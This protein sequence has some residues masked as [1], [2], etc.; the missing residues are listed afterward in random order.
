MAGIPTTSSYV[1]RQR[2][3]T[4]ESLKYVPVLLKKP[5]TDQPV[6]MRIKSTYWAMAVMPPFFIVCK[7]SPSP[8]LN[9]R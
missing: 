4:L 8:S 2:M 1:S 5:G 9:D 3:A 6:Q 7:L